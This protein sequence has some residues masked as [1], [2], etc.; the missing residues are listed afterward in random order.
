MGE[1]GQLKIYNGENL[2][3]TIDN[4]TQV[5]EYGNLVYN[6]QA[7]YNNIKIETTTPVS[8][9]KLII[10]NNKALSAKSTYNYNTQKQ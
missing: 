5:D 8:E 6:Y 9:G 7:N 4:N 1:N 3:A 2:I 10:E